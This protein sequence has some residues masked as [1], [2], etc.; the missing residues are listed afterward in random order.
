LYPNSTCRNGSCFY[1]FNAQNITVAGAVCVFD[2]SGADYR[3]DN[4]TCLPTCSWPFYITSEFGKF[5]C[6]FPC[7]E[8]Q[9]YYTNDTCLSSCSPPFLAINTT[10]GGICIFPC[11]RDQF[12]YQNTSCSDVCH[13]PFLSIN[14]SVGAFCNFKCQSGQALTLDNK[15]VAN[16]TS[17]FIK[18]TIAGNDYCIFPCPSNQ[19][20]H[21]DDTCRNLCK[22]PNII[23][24][25][26]IKG[27]NLC[28]SPSEVDNPLVDELAKFL[29]LVTLVTMATAAVLLPFGFDPYVAVMLLAILQSFF[30][31]LFYN[32]EY[33]SLVKAILGSFG[34]A[35]FSFLPN[36]LYWF[37]NEIPDLPSPRNFYVNK[38][39][40]Y[41]LYTSSQSLFM[42]S[43]LI[44]LN[45]LGFAA[46]F[47]P[48][49]E[50]IQRIK[51]YFAKNMKNSFKLR[52]FLSLYLQLAI[53][54]LLQVLVPDFSLISTLI[55]YILSQCVVFLCFLIIIFAFRILRSNFIMSSVLEKNHV[56]IE[57]YDINHN[58]IRYFGMFLILKK[59]LYAFAL[60][61]LYHIP[62]FQC[63]IPWLLNLIMMILVACYRPHNR[64]GL[65]SLDFINELGMLG[66]HCGV[67]SLAYYDAVKDYDERK[68]NI[69]GHVILGSI[70]LV[71]LCSLLFV[72]KENYVIVKRLFEFFKNRMK[73][74]EDSFKAGR[75]KIRNLKEVEHVRHVSKIKIRRI[76][77]VS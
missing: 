5:Y 56:L 50:K 6:K 41:F 57:D 52:L 17:P 22:P 66:V 25:T 4:D 48:N 36:P 71:F 34:V 65:N 68:R 35:V 44:I 21:P 26:V 10:V 43:T 12:Y 3:Y 73:R 76:R 77:V 53:T 31:C 32:V 46:S 20:L 55:S 16:C 58:V 70:G 61:M 45:L 51:N 54:A 59:A 38:Y 49:N 23:V 19:F 60:V 39:T 8:N 63:M 13:D 64:Y 27:I 24:P 30:F 74:E 28:I 72:W 67:L 11:P 15:C 37:V 75:G 29:K 40:G 18:L 9:Y 1:G 2:C 69:S 7:D 42:I 47:F 62:I 33:P 14:I